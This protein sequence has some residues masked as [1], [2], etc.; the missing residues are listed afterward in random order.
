[1][2]FL[3]YI[4]TREPDPPGDDRRSWEPNWRIWRWV[5]ATVA[6]A[7]ASTYSDGA[8]QAVLVLAAFGLL[9]KAAAEALPD[10]DGMRE[11]RQ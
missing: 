11:Y 1:M 7:V 2:P 4:H 9:C 6:F 8:A 3:A 10:G 5:I